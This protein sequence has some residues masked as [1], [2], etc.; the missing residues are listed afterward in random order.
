[1]FPNLAAHPTVIFRRQSLLDE[2]KPC[3]CL[4]TSQALA[5]LRRHDEAVSA[6]AP[7]GELGPLARGT[8]RRGGGG[9]G[10]RP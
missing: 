4:V 5:L 1:L 10:C 3:G 7:R 8:P 9:A 2:E 6:P